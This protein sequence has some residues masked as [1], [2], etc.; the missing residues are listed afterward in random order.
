MVS[1]P[2]A[3]LAVLNTTATQRSSCS[4]T[5]SESPAQLGQAMISPECVPSGSSISCPHPLQWT[6]TSLPPRPCRPG[7][8]AE[9][10]QPHELPAIEADDDLAINHRYRSRP[11]AELLEFLK[12][13]LVFLNVLIHE[14][15]ALLRKKLFLLVACP[16]PWLTVNGNVSCHQI[17]PVC[18]PSGCRRLSPT[19]N[20]PAKTT[21]SGK[22]T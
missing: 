17:P 16:S 7:P 5:R 22:S 14:G 1:S 4:L 3:Q 12:G 10:K 8:L 15:N 2:T 13:C 11:I 19:N 9:P 21:K 20:T 6:L 18:F